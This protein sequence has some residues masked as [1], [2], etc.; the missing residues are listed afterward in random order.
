[1]GQVVA[2]PPHLQAFESIK[3][4]FTSKRPRLRIVNST[5]VPTKDAPQAAK[6]SRMGRSERFIGPPERTNR[7]NRARAP[8]FWTDLSKLGAISIVRW[9]NPHIWTRPVDCRGCAFTARGRVARPARR[10][11]GAVAR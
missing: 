2:K 1:P 5:L 3:L 9:W 7:L 4:S 10:Y 8:R 6:P 11:Q